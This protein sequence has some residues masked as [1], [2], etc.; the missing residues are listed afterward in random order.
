[1]PL[2]SFLLL[3]KY[4]GRSQVRRMPLALDFAIVAAMKRRGSK[5]T[6]ETAACRIGSSALNAVHDSPIDPLIK[7]RIATVA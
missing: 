1:M 3:Q 6:A 7:P 2:P 5:I 4:P